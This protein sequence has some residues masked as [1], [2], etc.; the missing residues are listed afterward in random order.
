[1]QELYFPEERRCLRRRCGRS[2]LF[3]MGA[4][5]KGKPFR[6]AHTHCLLSQSGQGIMEQTN[7]C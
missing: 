1:M 5:M 4:K 6:S 2:N 7:A 3:N